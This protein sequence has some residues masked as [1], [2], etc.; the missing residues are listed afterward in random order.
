MK[1]AFLTFK[2]LL[3][4]LVVLL[5][6]ALLTGQERG[7][8]EQTRPAATAETTSS[9]AANPDA[10]IPAEN[11]PDVVAP[12]AGDTRLSPMLQ[13]IKVLWE[14]RQAERAALEEQ[15]RMAGDEATALAIQRE[16]EELMVQTELSILRIQADHARREGR[17]AD[18]EKI[19][20]AI[21]EMTSPPELPPPPERP[22]PANEQH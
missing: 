7:P 17:I 13:E 5:L 3:P 19:E 22:A 6:P 8:A 16:I 20:A 11:A 18:A 21:T 2:V 14:T 10:G 1:T 4:L 12:L 15:F 9:A